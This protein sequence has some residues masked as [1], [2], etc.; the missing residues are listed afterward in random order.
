MHEPPELLE[1]EGPDGHRWNLRLW[2]PER[3]SIGLTWLP[4]LGVPAAKYDGFAAALRGRGIGVAIH[5][6]RGTA[7]SSLRPSRRNDWGYSELI[8]QDIPTTIAAAK[9]AMPQQRWVLG[10]H[11]LGGQLAALSLAMQPAQAQALLLIATGVP[12]AGYFPGL[13]AL[14]VRLFAHALGPLTRLWGSFP[15]NRLNWA[16]HEA[17]QVMR[18]WAGTVRSG[19]YRQLAALPEI[20]AKLRALSQAALGLRFN[21]DWLVPAPSLSDLLGRIGEGRHEAHC[22]DQAALGVRADHFRWMKQPQAVV[23]ATVAWLERQ[24]TI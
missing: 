3:E 19:E 16:G 11:S 13:Q 23:D 4:A 15:G 7:G 9:Q 24:R 8:D 6:W 22:F 10:G 17:G 14:G 1:C 20:D 12:A 21:E 5:E 18:D 2:R